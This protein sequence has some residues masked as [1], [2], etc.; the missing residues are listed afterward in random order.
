MSEF[1][2][3]I[4]NIESTSDDAAERVDSI[5]RLVAAQVFALYPEI[6]ALD[7]RQG[8][9]SV[10]LES[11]EI[12]PG[13][14]INKRFPEWQK[15]IDAV[16]SNIKGAIDFY[17]TRSELTEESES[18]TFEQFATAQELTMTAQSVPFRFPAP[19][20]PNTESPWHKD[21]LHFAVAIWK[22]AGVSKI[23]L[24]QGCY[25]VGPAHPEQWAKGLNASE[26]FKVGLNAAQVKNMAS[27]PWQRETVESSETRAR[28]TELYR[29]AAPLELAGVLESLQCD[30]SGIEGATF[31][32]WAADIGA[33]TDSRS[34]LATFE[35]CRAIYYQM[36]AA[37]GADDFATFQQ[38]EP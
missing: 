15:C 26:L 29:A 12:V 36:S 13:Y 9:D 25:S 18:M 1:E 37:L 38:I 32:D 35:Q 11:G 30:I 28:V 22:G 17:M 4:S 5:V 24:W 20:D 34:A 21:A 31:A 33:D 6:A 16:E 23:P 3:L 8:S 2:N 27:T 10:K 7:S 19:A 14:D